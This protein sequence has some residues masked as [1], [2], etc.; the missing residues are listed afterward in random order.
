M[1]RPLI[2]LVIFSLAATTACD[3]PADTETAQAQAEATEE[4]PSVAG[5]E[6]VEFR[7]LPDGDAQKFKAIED[8]L[9][10]FS[11]AMI[12]V[13]HRY[14]DLHWAGVDRNWGYAE[15]QLEH[16]EEAIEAGIIRRPGRADSAR[17]FLDATIPSLQEAIEAQDGAAFDE[18]FEAFTNHCN[19]CHVQEEVAFIYVTPP[20]VRLSP[21]G[22]PPT[23]D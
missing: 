3:R 22:M 1:K 23:D 2:I 8:Q 13:G 19:S 20:E 17:P 9:A 16:I 15:Y 21:A 5:T 14:N 12:E 4:V 10:G 18:R 6:E 7:W 11:Q